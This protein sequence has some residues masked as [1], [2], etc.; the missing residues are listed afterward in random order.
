MDAEVA[1]VLQAALEKRPAADVGTGD[2]Q[3]GASLDAML[4]TQQSGAAAR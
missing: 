2:V 1:A 3:P 4:G